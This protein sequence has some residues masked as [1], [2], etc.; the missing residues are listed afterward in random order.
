MFPSTVWHSVE[1]FE[2]DEERIT[3]PFNFSNPNFVTPFYKNMSDY[4]EMTKNNWMWRNFRGIMLL[5]DKN[6]LVSR[7]KKETGKK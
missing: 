3:I 5:L 2:G 4:F 7:I 6:Y 1:P